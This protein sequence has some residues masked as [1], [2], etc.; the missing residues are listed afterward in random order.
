MTNYTVEMDGM[1]DP[2]GATGGIHVNAYHE[3]GMLTYICESIDTIPI[4]KLNA[5]YHFLDY[6]LTAT[7]LNCG[8]ITQY[9]DFFVR[10]QLSTRFI[11]KSSLNNRLQAKR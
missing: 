10:I 9:L 7:N 2:T 8:S 6:S 5:G 4:G 3:V 1:Y 11:W